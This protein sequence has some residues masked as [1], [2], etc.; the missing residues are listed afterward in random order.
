M[1][2]NKIP[3]VVI[4][5]LVTYLRILKDRDAGPEDYISSAELGDLAAVNSA[6]VRKDLAMFGEFGK[7]GVGYPVL[8]LKAELIKI[9]GADREMS[10]AIFGIGELGTALTRFLSTRRRFNPEYR[11][12]VKALFDVDKKKIGTK[13]EGLVIRPLSDL[14]EVARKEEIKIG[15]ITVPSFAA[16]DVVNEAI[17]SGIKGFLNFA[18]VKL[19]TPPD[20]RVHYSDVTSDLQELAFYL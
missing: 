1:I 7:Q 9:L 2:R 5:R 12:V 17:A 13:V 14:G 16:Q 11:F 6:Q 4:K 10:V 19:K 20:V 8:R 18:P 15:I 3:D